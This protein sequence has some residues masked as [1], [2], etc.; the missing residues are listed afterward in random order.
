MV[1][2]RSTTRNALRKVAKRAREDYKRW[3]VGPTGGAGVCE[4]IMSVSC[5]TVCVLPF[6]VT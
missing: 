5:V 1:I 6:T 3:M 2:Q 4:G